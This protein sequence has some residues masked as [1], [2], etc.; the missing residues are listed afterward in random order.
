MLHNL[1]QNFLQLS[2]ETIPTSSHICS[3]LSLLVLYATVGID[4]IGF[5]IVVP[6][7]PFYAMSLG[8]SGVVLGFIMS[9]FSIFQ[10]I[11]STIM[12]RVSDKYG[13]RPVILLSL[14]GSTIGFVS[15]GFA[16]SIPLICVSR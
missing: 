14:L 9:L 1:L 6:L 3:K 10:F 13:R 8:A 16:T 11:G 4:M 12:G 7:L 2:K 5:G 15:L